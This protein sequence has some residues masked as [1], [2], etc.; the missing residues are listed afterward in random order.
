MKKTWR[1]LYLTA[2]VVTLIVL[3]AAPA[4]ADEDRKKIESL[5]EEEKEIT[6]ETEEK[7]AELQGADQIPLE[8]IYNRQVILKL[9]DKADPDLSKYEMIEQNLR[10]GPSAGQWKTIHIPEKLDYY[11]ELQMI[12]QMD[13]IEL[14]S[15]DQIYESSYVPKDTYYQSHQDYLTMIGMER[16]WDITR[17][18]D[19]VKTAVID[20][21]VYQGHNDLDGRLTSGY[22]AVYGGSVYDDYNGH[23]TFVTGIIAANMNQTGVTG[24]APFTKIEPVNVEYEGSVSTTGVIKGVDYAIDSNVDIINMSFGGYTNNTTLQSVLW[25]AY[26]SGIVLIA[27]TGNDQTNTP[28]YPA[29]YPW[30]I[31]VG[32]TDTTSGSPVVADFSN[33]GYHVDVTAPGVNILSTSTMGGYE[34][35][36]GTSFSTPIVSGLASL[37]KAEH[38][39]W[40]PPQVEFALQNGSRQFRTGESNPWTGFGQVDGYKALTSSISDMGTDRSSWNITKAQKLS[41]GVE[42]ERLNFPTDKDLYS[43][44]MKFPG[45]VNLELSHPAS[46]IDM[47]FNVY[48]EI[49]GDVYEIYS[50]DIGVSGESESLTFRAEKGRYYVGVYEYYENWSRENYSLKMDWTLDQPERLSG[51]TRFDTSAEISKKGWPNGSDTVV[52]ATGF[53]FPDALAG[54]PLAYELDAPVLLTRSDRLVE[55]TKKEM[56]RLGAEDVYILGGTGAIS[57]TV[58]R[59]ISQMGFDVKRLSGQNRYETSVKIANELLSLQ[60][61]NQFDQTVLSYGNN[62]PDALAS[63][64]YAAQTGLPILLTATDKIPDSTQTVLSRVDKTIVVGGTGVISDKVLDQVPNGTRYAGENRFDTSVQLIEGLEMPT[65]GFYIAT[66]FEFA[67]ALTGSVLAAKDEKPILL[68]RS[69]RIPEEVQ[70]FIDRSNSNEFT[71]LGG[72]GAI[73]Q[74]VGAELLE[75]SN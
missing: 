37:I 23:G 43:L 25:D 73:S 33:Y 10:N 63:A 12:K 28:S 42:K 31:A 56:Q 35:G 27:A 24:V 14:A 36:D 52:L 22:D 32:A 45:E 3:G 48:Q 41:P 7:G 49:D 64:S 2:F 53:D 6:F 61:R 58:K 11:E 18:S 67:D 66:G 57:D 39:D 72:T 13:G 5:A 15:P 20:S 70:S 8:K 30:V 59:E 55:E 71:I 60:G 54:S 26:E 19:R 17:G 9:R 16:A 4:S 75:R 46:H 68:V 50:E 29:A 1:A 38:P 65:D 74:E 69:D 40:T 51:S 44:E 62:F 21:G 47:G 34:T